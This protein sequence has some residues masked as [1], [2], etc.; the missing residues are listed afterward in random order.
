MGRVNGPTSR[1]KGRGSIK[2]HPE[3]KAAVSGL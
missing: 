1:F 3:A 2:H